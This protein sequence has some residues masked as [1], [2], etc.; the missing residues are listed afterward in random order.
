MKSTNLV[1]MFLIYFVLGLMI[2]GC[3]RITDTD[4]IQGQINENLNPID[5][6]SSNYFKTI[7]SVLVNISVSDTTG[8][9]V[10][11]ALVTV[12]EKNGNQG[13]IFKSITKDD[14]TA[15][16]YVLVALS[17]NELELEIEAAGHETY[18][19]DITIDAG[20]IKSDHTI[21]IRQAITTL[22]TPWED[23]D[24]DGVPNHW[25]EYD[26]DPTAAFDIQFPTHYL[27]YEDLYPLDS[28]DWD[29]NDLV[30]LVEWGARVNG[31]FNISAISGY[32]KLIARGADAEYLSDFKLNLM[33]PTQLDYLAEVNGV[34]LVAPSGNNITLPLFTN[35]GLCF[36]GAG[37]GLINTVKGSDYYEG[38][39]STFYVA[40]STPISINPDEV[41]DPY[42]MVYNPDSMITCD[43]HRPNFP[44]ISGSENPPVNSNFIDS[45]GFPYTLIIPTF[46]RGW[47][48]P[49]ERTKISDAYPGF[50]AWV[51]SNFGETNPLTNGWFLAPYPDLV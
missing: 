16:G 20:Q 41:Y 7:Q 6:N 36:S 19:G 1:R 49:L 27:A 51:D 34:P 15:S 3:A 43:I 23:I 5:S 21:E 10:S 31:W 24:G 46:G 8:T 11:S 2:S 17:E 40:L 29:V 25:D 12:R 44:A 42:L 26:D 37:P 35:T 9:P 33:F 39:M 18:T 22:D 47:K 50:Q 48:W 32:A 14:G 28:S 4:G 38:D 30:V 45:N 13:T